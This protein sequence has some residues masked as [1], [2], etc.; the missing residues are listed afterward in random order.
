MAIY[1]I[2]NMTNKAIKI[3]YSDNVKGRMRSLRTA[4]PDQLKL[5]GTIDGDKVDEHRLHLRFTRDRIN[6]EWFRPSGELTSFIRACLARRGGGKPAD[7]LPSIGEACNLMS[8]CVT[9]TNNLIASSSDLKFHVFPVGTYEDYEWIAVGG[10]PDFGV[11]V[12]VR[13]IETDIGWTETFRVGDDWRTITTTI[14]ET[15]A[16]VDEEVATAL[17]AAS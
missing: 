17:A 2:Q 9:A 8:I 16:R 11:G 7:A 3:G 12:Y 13:D 4:S 14:A 5:L 15:V 6:R 10:T 1:F